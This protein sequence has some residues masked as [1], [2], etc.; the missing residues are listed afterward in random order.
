[1]GSCR[2]WGTFEV[3]ITVEFT[4]GEPSLGLKHVLSFRDDGQTHE[5]TLPSIRTNADQ[6]KK[7]KGKAIPSEILQKV[8]CGKS[9][10]RVDVRLIT[11]IM[12]ITIAIANVVIDSYLSRS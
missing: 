4:S 1:M 9:G 11:L 7:K 10:S 8:I 2:G 5:I 12:T 6:R 3:K